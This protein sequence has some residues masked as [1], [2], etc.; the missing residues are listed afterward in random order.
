[1]AIDYYASGAKTRVPAP[2]CDYG[3]LS[4]NWQ[5]AYEAAALAQ[6]KI[7]A[8]C[9]VPVGSLLLGLIYQHDA[10]GATTGLKFGIA[11]EDGGSTLSSVD[12]FVTVADSS[13][14]GNSVAWIVPLAV[15]EDIY[16]TVKQTGAGT[17][18]GTITAIPIYVFRQ[19]S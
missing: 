1:M 12:N 10:M 5:G 2:A 15:T 18:T 16:I 7:V 17:A 8:L 19:N 9:R 4:V 6:N 14:A 13:S 11:D 3:N